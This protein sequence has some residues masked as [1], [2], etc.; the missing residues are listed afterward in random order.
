MTADAD[1]VTAIV[2]YLPAAAALELYLPAYRHCRI[3]DLRSEPVPTID[4]LVWCAELAAANHCLHEPQ[5]LPTGPVDLQFRVPH[6]DELL[7]AGP[8]SPAGRVGYWTWTRLG[9]F[10]SLDAGHIDPGFVISPEPRSPEAQPVVC[11]KEWFPTGTDEQWFATIPQDHSLPT[12]FY[13]RR[14]RLFDPGPPAT[15]EFI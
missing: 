9:N 13:S 7:P 5:K 15:E 14:F 6:E 4:E 1:T 10:T 8:A 3:T 2:Y 11:P 12:E